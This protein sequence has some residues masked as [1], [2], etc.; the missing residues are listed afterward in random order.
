MG[1][2][3]ITDTIFIMK[4]VLLILVAVIGF[5]ISANAQFSSTQKVCNN[6]AGASYVFY[7]N[8][9]VSCFNIYGESFYTGKKYEIT[10]GGTRIIIYDVW[11]NGD[12]KVYGVEINGGRL[13]K[14]WDAK[15][16]TPSVF[17]P[18]RCQ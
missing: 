7:S 18:D 9:T 13:E 10:S 11:Y 16:L 5:G 3:F 6:L 4:K 2:W 8:G 15:D 17:T 14:M 1:R 12:N